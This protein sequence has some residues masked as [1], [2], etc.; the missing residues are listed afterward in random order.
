MTHQAQAV[1]R[2]EEQEAPVVYTTEREGL[3][4]PPPGLARLNERQPLARMRYADGHLGWLVT[5]YPEARA[6]LADERFSSRAELRHPPLSAM[7]EEG[8]PRP[9]PPGVFAMMDEPAHRR[10]RRLVSAE[11][12]VR[13]MRLLASWIGQ[14]TEERLAAMEAGGPPVDL[15]TAF[16]VPIP[17]RVICE[18]LGVPLGERGRFLRDIEQWSTF[19]DGGNVGERREAF[20]QLAASMGRLVALKR[21]EPGDDILSGLVHAR[22]PVT[23]E[24][25]SGLAFMLL[26]AG[27]DSIAAQ[28]TMSVA[29]LLTER[30]DLHAALRADPGLTDAAVEEL[31]RFLS[32]TQHGPLR[33]ALQDVEIGGQVIRKGENVMISLSAA[34]RDPRRFADPH[35]L[36]LGRANAMSHLAF[37]YGSHQCL[38]QQLARTELR[39]A[40]AALLRRFPALRPAVP[41]GE[42]SVRPNRPFHRLQELP[43]AW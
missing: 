10:Y 33:T 13:R 37:G 2:E 32:V 25:A 39:I 18:M 31:L 34:N 40:L 28:L 15:H 3:F 16:S 29:V 17:L 9:A 27:F 21:A 14:V 26:V 12:S 5:G 38:A 11:F 24:E 36:D 6:V 42:L 8:G 35:R 30:P 20:A 23:D 19:R 4:G 22:D 7:R 41:P 1:S 43:V